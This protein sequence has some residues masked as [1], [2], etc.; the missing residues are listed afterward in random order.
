MSEVS[1]KHEY[2]I[3]P[4]LWYSDRQ[5]SFVPKHFTVANTELSS[6]SDLWIKTKLRGRYAL[7]HRTVQSGS[8]NLY[9]G[10]SSVVPAFEDPNEAVM[11]ELMWS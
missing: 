3:D 10:F 5:V 8:H 6:E 2:T 11:Y 1:E 7:A 4:V 9:D